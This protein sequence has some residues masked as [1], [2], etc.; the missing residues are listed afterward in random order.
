MK[1]PALI[2]LALLPG[3]DPVRARALS[4]VSRERAENQL[5]DS[6]PT[7]PFCELVKNAKLYF[8]QQVRVRAE[9]RIATE[10]RYLTDDNCQLSHDDQIGAGQNVLDKKQQEILD[11]QLRAVSSSE[12]G[13]RAMITVLGVLRNSSRRDFAWYRYRFDINSLEDIA[14]VAVPYEGEL[15]ETVTYRANVRPDAHYGLALIPALRGREHYATRIE[16]TNLRQFPKLGRVRDQT[17]TQRV[18]FTVL[19]DKIRQ[20]TELRWNRTLKCKILRV[21]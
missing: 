10:G 1:I 11:A 8:G 6:I 18:L 13:G 21:E 19:S 15:Q 4:P 20:V 7:V 3:A 9:Y 2:L 17:G 14:P 16:W 12:Y 5:K